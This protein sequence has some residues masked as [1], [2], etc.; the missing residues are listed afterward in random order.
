MSQARN[1]RIGMYIVDMLCRGVTDSE[2][3]FNKTQEEL[4]DV[5][6]TLSQ[7]PVLMMEEFKVKLK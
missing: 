6:K 7:P 2:Y 5:L 1:I 4:D 3:F